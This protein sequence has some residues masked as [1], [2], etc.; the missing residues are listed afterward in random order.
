MCKATRRA[1]LPVIC[2]AGCC[3]LTRRGPLLVVVPVLIRGC[4]WLQLKA[5]RK[6]IPIHLKQESFAG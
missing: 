3:C 1:H 4:L 6:F 2:R 5:T